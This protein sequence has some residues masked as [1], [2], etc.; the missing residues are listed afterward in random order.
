MAKNEVDS[1]VLLLAVIAGAAALLL[2]PSGESWLCGAAGLIL[3]ITLFAYDLEG[4]R[5]ILQTFAFSAVCGFSLAVAVAPIAPALFSL[6]GP[7]DPLL[8]GKWLPI[9]WLG[10]TILF[11][12][13]DRARMTGR[14]AADRTIP[15]ARPSLR[16]TAMPAQ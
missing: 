3:L 5:S 7:A 14:V 4:V 9:L 12:V 11:I 2:I 13:I 6:T 10:S 16:V 15:P 8:G 1:T